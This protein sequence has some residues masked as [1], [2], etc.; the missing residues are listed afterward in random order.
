MKIHLI[1]SALRVFR[2]RPKEITNFGSAWETAKL[3]AFLAGWQTN[4][5]PS[6]FDIFLS[7]KIWVHL[8]GRRSFLSQL[9]LLDALR[10]WKSFSRGSPSTLWLEGPHRLHL[11]HQVASSWK[12]EALRARPAAGDPIKSGLKKTRLY[13][14]DGGG[15]RKQENYDLKS[16][17][18]WPN[19]S[20]CAALRYNSDCPWILKAKWWRFRGKSLFSQLNLPIHDRTVWKH[21]LRKHSIYFIFFN[22]YYFLKCVCACV[23]RCLQKP[24]KD[25]QSPGARVT[26]NR[27]NPGCWELNV[28]PLVEQR[29]LSTSQPSF[30]LCV[31]FL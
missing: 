17:A 28:C 30:Q 15:W 2:R 14:R 8:G 25:V 11:R 29:I 4:L 26:G 6:F 23:C 18:F 31:L 19:Q 22:I 1:S 12:G 21:V 20:L 9:R 24:E 10:V 3:Q 5:E 27:C 13:S 7:K 16:Y